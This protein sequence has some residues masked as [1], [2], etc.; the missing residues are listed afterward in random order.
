MKKS[1]ILFGLGL[2]MGGLGLTAAPRPVRPIPA[3]ER[4]V[5]I[6]IDGLRPDRLLLA[7][8]PV[9]HAMVQAGTYTFWAKTTAV[10]ITLPSHV[11]MLTGMTPDKHGIE[12]NSD[13][14][15]STPVYPL[16]PT[17]FETAKLGGYTTALVTGKTK[18]SPL[19]KPGT[20]DHLFMPETNG[21]EDD[22]V[23]DE[24]VKIIQQFKPDLLFVHFPTVDRMGHKFGWGSAEQLAAIGLADRG[25]GKVMAA[26]DES[27]LRKSTFVIITS[28]H[29]GQGKTHGADDA[30]SR[31]IPWIA[32]GP[33]VVKNFDL[34]QFAELEVHTEDTAVTALYLLGAP[35][36]VYLQGKSILSAFEIV[37][38]E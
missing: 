14:P 26:L 13:L 31:H 35:L 3:I 34:T 33:G 30:R 7:D 36:P 22:Q 6:S 1:L 11:S 37:P 18:F 17:I 4:V 23:A 5:I 16:F 28:D 38:K 12:W 10:A 29:G 24:A 9:I 32:S 25:V 27:G 19:A 2:L 8:T 21:L 20:I 15:F